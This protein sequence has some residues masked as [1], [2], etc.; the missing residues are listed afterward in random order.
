MTIK[1]LNLLLM[2]ANKTFK[3]EKKLLQIIITDSKKSGRNSRDFKDHL[4]AFIQYSLTICNF[5]VSEEF[6]KT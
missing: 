2:A 6:Q 4:R 1:D 3:L 5:R